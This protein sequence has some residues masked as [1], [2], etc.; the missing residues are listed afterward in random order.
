MSL[1]IDHRKVLFWYQSQQHG[2]L[3]FLVFNVF[4][5]MPV[6][7]IYLKADCTN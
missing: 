7:I 4:I 5:F 3:L 6:I 2:V 1:S